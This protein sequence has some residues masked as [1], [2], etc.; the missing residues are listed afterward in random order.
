MS[1]ADLIDRIDTAK[2]EHQ[3]ASDLIAEARERLKSPQPLPK[4][5]K[6][7]IELKEILEK[8]QV[9][10]DEISNWSLLIGRD[11]TVT[12]VK[13]LGNLEVQDLIQFHHIQ[14]KAVEESVRQFPSEDVPDY[15]PDDRG[16]A[17]LTNDGH[18]DAFRHTYWNSL[19]TQEFGEP[20][21]SEY[22]TAHEAVPD[23]GNYADREAMDLYN[24]EVGRR[25]AVDNPNASPEELANLVRQA[26]D[27]GELI[28]IDRDGDLAWSN[29]EKVPPGQ[30][31]LANDQPRSGGQPLPQ[32]DGE[33]FTE[34]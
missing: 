25:I 15:V 5:S 16:V 3:R 6:E 22:A 32:V 28:V 11:L 31:G 7:E 17:W 18:R 2:S 29:D 1:V 10:G 21:T 13:A 20:W 12:E 27:D 4:P 30:H 14:E 8:Y 24:N 34:S 33:T 19:M 9:Q 23:E 26:L